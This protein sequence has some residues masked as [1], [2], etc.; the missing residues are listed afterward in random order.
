MLESVYSKV[1]TSLFGV[2]DECKNASALSLFFFLSVVSNLIEGRK[3]EAESNDFEGLYENTYSYG[4]LL[5]LSTLLTTQLNNFSSDQIKSL[6]KYDTDRKAIE[7]LVP[8]KNL[9]VLNTFIQLI[10]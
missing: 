6:D 7:I 3:K 9:A 2:I 4:F 8:V 10:I 1:K 5:E